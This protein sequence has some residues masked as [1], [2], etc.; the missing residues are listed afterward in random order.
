[1]QDE[2]TK[3]TAEFKELGPDRV[4]SGMVTGRWSSEKRS[5]AR[6]WLERTDIEKWQKTSTGNIGMASMRK[7]FKSG[8]FAAGI[9]II[10]GLIALARVLRRF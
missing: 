9:G 10:F 3:W 7:K 6:Q 4:R 8:Y 1:M 5:V 2:R